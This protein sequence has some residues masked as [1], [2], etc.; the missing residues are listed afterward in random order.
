MTFEFD[1]K[2]MCLYNLHYPVYISPVSLAEILHLQVAKILD[3]PDLDPSDL[4]FRPMTFT[5]E[6]NGKDMGLYHLLYLVYIISASLVEI[7]LL[8]GS[9]NSKQMNFTDIAPLDLIFT[10]MILEIWIW[11]Q[12]Y[13]C[14]SSFLSKMHQLS[15]C[16]WNI[17]PPNWSKM[18][19]DRISPIL[20]HWTLFWPQW[21]WPLNL[22]AK[23]CA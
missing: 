22:M 19:N 17:L 13:V 7:F 9:Q 2:N 14:R 12:I 4:I 20:P 3:F 6:L 15:I 11:W 16:L 8:Q 5:F 1:G 21:P 10:S 18:P 23:I